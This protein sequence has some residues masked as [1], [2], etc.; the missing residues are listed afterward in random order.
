MMARIHHTILAVVL[1]AAATLTAQAE[2]IVVQ[3]GE[4]VQVALDRAADG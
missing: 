1:W 2:R 3:P 4:D